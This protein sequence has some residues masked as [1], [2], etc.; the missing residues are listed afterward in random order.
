M[1]GDLLWTVN[2]KPSYMV[3]TDTHPTWELG[4]SLANPFL[5][6]TLRSCD[7]LNGSLAQTCAAPPAVNS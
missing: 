5:S 2:G 4:T 3:A 1:G 7:H 6:I